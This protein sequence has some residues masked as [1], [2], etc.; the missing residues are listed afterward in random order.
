MSKE[1]D[2]T[3]FGHFYDLVPLAI[4]ILIILK[5]IFISMH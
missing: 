2:S 1:G 5:D 4:S 3:G